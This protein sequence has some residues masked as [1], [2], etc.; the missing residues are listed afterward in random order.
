[1]ILR[2][3]CKAG[4]ALKNKGTYPRTERRPVKQEVHQR[5]S[6]LEQIAP[7]TVLSGGFFGD[8]YGIVDDHSY[9]GQ[10]CL[11]CKMWHLNMLKVTLDNDQL[12]TQFFKYIYYNPLRVHVSS[13][14]LLIFRTSNCIYT[15]SG[16]VTL[17]K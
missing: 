13:N 12:I 8:L 16:I 6:G 2:V 14:I 10:A 15:A 11:F 1:M 9:R 7:N 3:L 4:K 5:S 17:S